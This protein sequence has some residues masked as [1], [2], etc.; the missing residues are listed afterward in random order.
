MAK[1]SLGRGLD[2]LFEP[3]GP[4]H[5]GDILMIPVTDI[6]GNPYQPRKTFREEELLE[7]MDSLAN[8]GILQPII[9][10]KIPSRGEGYFLVAG[11]R[12]Y[13]AACRL[14]W[15]TIP[16]IVKDIPE[17]SLLEIALVEN[18]QRSDLNPVEIA[19]G[20]NQLIEECTW[21]Q[22][23]LAK[24]LGMK[25]ST[26]ANYLRILALPIETLGLLETG[27]LNMGHAKILLGIKDPQMQKKWENSIIEEGLSVRSLEKNIGKKTFPKKAVP[28]WA[29]SSQETLTSSFGRAV[30]IKPVKK[31]FQITVD[32]QD[33]K[34]LNDFLG[35]LGLTPDYESERSE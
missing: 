13:R 4:S 23:Q 33:E 29:V 17:T 32:I 5:E 3:E 35:R 19:V 21:T 22:E 7:M 12:R 15:E 25:R 31:A 10:T 1:N 26:I 18:L 20:L 14:G 24:H 2:S 8:H 16:G 9:L 34:D 11:E 27:E 6:Q 28:E 30:R